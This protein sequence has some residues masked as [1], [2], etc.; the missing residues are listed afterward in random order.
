MKKFIKSSRPK[1]VLKNFIIFVPFFFTL[2]KWRIL[3]FDENITLITNNFLAFIS[4]CCASIIGYQVNDLMD[5]EYDK[6]HP[7]K[8][9]RPISLGLISILEIVIFIIILF[10]ISI[11]C[12]YLVD[13]KI[14]YII[15]SYIILSFSYSRLIKSIP[16]LDILCISIFY[17]TRMIVGTLSINF[18]I[19][20]WLYI[21]T[22]LASLLI[23]LI[24]RFSESKHYKNVRY[25][26]IRVFY[27]KKYVPRV[28]YLVLILNILVYAIYCFSEI[29]SNQRNFLF[30]ITSIFFSYGIYRYYKVTSQGNLGESPEEVII[31]DKHIIASVIF[32]LTTMTAASELN[33]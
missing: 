25:S 21:L 24:K 12:A 23:I 15:F 1:Q 7:I 22:F 29:L 33:F 14:I 6:N 13:S 3:S 32:Y 16:A 20:I 2:E 28:I 26:D 31:K 11:A 27:S 17:I 4:F 19:S 8:K 18:E 5:R 10:L 9:N 30:L